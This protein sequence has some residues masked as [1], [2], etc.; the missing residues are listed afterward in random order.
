VDKECGE[1]NLSSHTAALHATLPFVND[2][3]NIGIDEWLDMAEGFSD[4]EVT[5]RIAETEQALRDLRDQQLRLVRR[6]NALQ[7]LGRCACGNTS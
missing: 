2:H 7:S 4:R 1:S 3:E 6:L 5:K